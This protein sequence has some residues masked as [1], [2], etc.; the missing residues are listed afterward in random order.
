MTEGLIGVI[1]P[2]Y[3]VEKY[4][5]ECIESILVQTYTN[6]RLILV[7]DRTPDNAGKICDEY[8]QKD[9]RITVI[10]QENAGVTRARA[11][12]VEEANGCEFVMFVDSDDKLLPNALEEFHNLMDE[13]TDIVMCTSYYTDTENYTAIDSYDDSKRINTS[14][15][16]KRLICIKG[17]MPWGKLFRKRLFN[18]KTFNVPREIIFGEDI[19][20]NIRLA[21]SSA[22]DIKI[23]LNP[24]YFYRQHSESVCSN[25]RHT[26]EYEEL[27][28]IHLLDSIPQ[29]RIDEFSH[30]YISIRLFF[31]RVYG[32]N[33]LPSPKWSNTCFHTQLKSDIKKYN[34]KIGYFEKL[35][36]YNTNVIARAL[37]IFCRKIY[38]IYKITKQISK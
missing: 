6:F 13:S 1:V 3:K 17:G 22:K 19:L 7:D 34:F 30:E 5:A 4:I 16:V 21:F 31:W 23:I 27:Y 18:E 28:R 12:G 8:A 10:H 15:F 35:L 29:Y 33:N 25:F 32:G 38:S 26:A 20:M 14:T 11:R 36:L 9:S 24:L 2:V 37:I